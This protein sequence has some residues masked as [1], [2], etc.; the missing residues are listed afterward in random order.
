MRIAHKRYFYI[1]EGATLLETECNHVA[2]YVYTDKRERPC[3]LAFHGKAQ[4]PDFHYSFKSEERRAEHIRHYAEGQAATLESKAARKQE[5]NYFEHTL[6]VGQIMRNSWGY[7]QTNVDYFQ[8]TK[9]ISP[10]M[11]EIRPISQRTVEATGS[12]SSRVAPV[13]DS[14]HGESMRKRVTVDNAVKIHSWGSWAYPVS[15]N[16]T[17]HCSWYA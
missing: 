17:T 15:D 9:I 5:R 8:V 10:K 13:R 2:V 14:F 1:P 7:D 4:K 12:M 3:A 6:K 11:V 16:E